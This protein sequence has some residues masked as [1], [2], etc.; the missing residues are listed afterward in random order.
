MDVELVRA[1]LV[2]DSVGNGP[3]SLMGTSGRWLLERGD[4]DGMRK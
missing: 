4:G 3:I 2:I 1:G